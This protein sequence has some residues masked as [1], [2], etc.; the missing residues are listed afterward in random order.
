MG[1]H[2]QKSGMMR[3]LGELNRFAFR[4][5]IDGAEE[6]RLATANELAAIDPSVIEKTGLIRRLVLLTLDDRLATRRFSLV[7]VV[8]IPRLGDTTLGRVA[9]LAT[10]ASGGIAVLGWITGTVNGVELSSKI[11]KALDSDSSASQRAPAPSNGTT[12]TNNNPGTPTP[13][14]P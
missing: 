10:I 7:R 13:P 12:T 3:T 5:F 4:N 1:H 2:I 11:L 6:G 8:K 9:T 14:S